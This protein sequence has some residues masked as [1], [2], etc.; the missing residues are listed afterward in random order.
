MK[1]DHNPWSKKELETYIFLLCA[2]AD[3]NE[4]AEEIN[5][6]KSKVDIRTFEKIYQE[7]SRDT[8][9]TRFEKIEDN[10]NH[11]DYSHMELMDLQKQMQE[12]FMS[13]SKLSM[14]EE[15]LK[16]IMGNMLY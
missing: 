11:H 9:D 13:D 8:E 4:S 1:S 14:T 12:I 5:L 7:F 2:N 6:I 3:A 10:I 16:K 15:K